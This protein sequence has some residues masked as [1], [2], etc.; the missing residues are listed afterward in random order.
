MTDLLIT[1]YPWTLTLHL[2]SVISWMAGL[3]YLPRLFVY[4]AQRE[5]GSESSEMLKVMES[6]L[7]KLIMRPA[8][9]ASW[10]FGL[11]LALTPGVVDW[12]FGWFYAKVALLLGLFASHGFMGRWLKDFAHD[13]NTRSH[14][15][16]RYA[17]EVPTLL[18]VF[19]VGLVIIKPF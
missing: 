5:V 15:F 8:M 3:L 6:K 18:M 13:T 19:I 12:G 7:Y 1:L 10:L 4:H 2:I 17:N 16:Y 14:K 11:I 9:L